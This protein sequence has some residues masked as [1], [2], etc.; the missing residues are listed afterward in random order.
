[1]KGMVII[2]MKKLIAVLLT[3]TLLCAFAGCGEKTDINAK[4]EGVLTYA[5]YTDAA[6]DTQVVVEGFIQAKQAYS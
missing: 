2:T 4:S 3:L 5:Q 1:M 6:L